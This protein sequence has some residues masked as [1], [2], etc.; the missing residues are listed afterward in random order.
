LYSD[1]WVISLI[2][3]I[4][5]IISYQYHNNLIYDIPWINQ[6][7]SFFRKQTALHYSY[8]FHNFFTV[9][10]WSIFIGVLFNIY[11]CFCTF[12]K[13][14]SEFP[15]VI[16]NFYFYYRDLIPP[17]IKQTWH[18]DILFIIYLVYFV[19]DWQK[20][21]MCVE[22]WLWYRTIF[23]QTLSLFHKSGNMV[24]WCY[25]GLP[26]KWIILRL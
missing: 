17:R 2:Q 5:R 25:T 6:I 20:Y 11:L 13:E 12:D 21:K 1:L 9:T 14:H 7:L 3:V 26:R 22:P 23:S 18:F 8:H 4:L 16:T 15:L 10:K 24:V 19:V